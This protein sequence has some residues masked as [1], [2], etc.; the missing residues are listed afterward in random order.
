MPSND[1][2][3]IT[4]SFTP[5]RTRATARH[6]SVS[7]HVP[8]GASFSAMVDS[9]TAP[10]APPAVV[11]ATVVNANDLPREALKLD[12]FEG[13]PSDRRF[14][15]SWLLRCE[16]IHEL[17]A[18]SDGDTR[19][20][21][22]LASGSLPSTSAAGQWFDSQQNTPATAFA[23][24]PDFRSRFLHRFG[25]TPQ[26]LLRFEQQFQRLTQGTDSVPD[27]VQKIDRERDF[28]AAHQRVFDDTAVRNILISGLRKVISAHVS[29]VLT[30]KPDADY[31]VCVGVANSHPDAASRCSD[32]S[33]KPRL[34]RMQGRN[35]R[36]NEHRN[37]RNKPYR[38]PSKHCAYH[39]C[40]GHT[41]DECH[42]VRR[43]KA[44]G[45]WREG[46]QAK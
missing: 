20:K 41:L 19:K 21:L 12:K 2:N 7:F 4:L 26:D 27:F 23:D 46:M 29:S 9:G 30:L 37:N 8:V 6:I 22:A 35:T 11:A 33:H 34:Q 45:K 17:L 1:H 13:R 36:G 14:A 43:L 3:H 25:P 39:K 18:Y 38:D 42:A 10:A 16:R 28:L 44:A 31:E 5:G 32:G 40:D 15:A 24:W